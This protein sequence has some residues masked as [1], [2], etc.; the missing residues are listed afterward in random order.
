MVNFKKF[1]LNKANIIEKLH[2]ASHN[3]RFLDNSF[4]GRFLK[5]LILAAHGRF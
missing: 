4:L 3:D 1:V 5:T 2:Q